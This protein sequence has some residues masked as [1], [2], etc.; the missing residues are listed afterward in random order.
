MRP[1]TTRPL[2]LGLA[3]LTVVA[4]AVIVGV[5]LSR[6]LW[7]EGEITTLRSL[8][9]GSLPDLP[10]DPSNRYADDERAAELGYRL[11][12]DTRFSANGSV[13]C[14]TCHDANNQFQDSLPLAQ[15]VG[16]TN[17]RAMT[18]VGTAYSPWLFWDGRK[19]SQWAQAL[20]PMESAVEHGGNRTQYAHLIATYYRDRYEAVFGPLPDF[21]H[22]PVSAGP[23]ADPHASAA[24]EAMAQADRDAVTQTYAN[25]GK[26]IAA[27]ERLIM[28]GP[29]RF[30]AY[31]E[32]VLAK[33]TQ[34]MNTLYTQDEVA[35]LRLFIGEANCL[36]CHN[37]PLFTD[38][39]FHNTGVP[40]VSELPEDIGR[41][42]G[43]IQ[44]RADEFNCVSVYSDA[45]PEHDCA[46]LRFMVTEGDELLYAF[47]PP[48]LRGV[49]E[50][51]PY[52][53]AGQVDTLIDVLTHYNT[54]PTAPIGHSEI[55]PLNLS[56][57]Q[58]SQLMAFLKTLSGPLA[59]SPEWLTPPD[60]TE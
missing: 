39:H 12:F 49:A 36:Q 24:W 45:S 18:I 31:V 43:A 60:E 19:D 44:V 28:P 29:S 59:T 17:R 13:A 2:L 35:G 58:M 32:A 23:V 42:Q 57:T 37:G 4:L 22:L 33:D 16:T 55:K 6:P 56:E 5:R 54:A 30:D 27:Y 25:M 20:G 15:G 48:S 38:N 34:Q 52:M 3:G 1:P 11:F 9:L 51:A 26:A 41:A 14:A 46:E 7:T 50:R 53:H 10:P 21:S 8:W 40:P 47:R